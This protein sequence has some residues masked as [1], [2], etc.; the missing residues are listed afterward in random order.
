MVNPSRGPVQTRQ[1]F[2]ELRRR[3]LHGE[4]ASNARVNIAAVAAELQSSTGAVREA[5]AMLEAEAFVVSEPMKGYR[6]R[7]ISPEDLRN[8]V[9]ARIDIDN[10]CLADALAHGGDDWEASIVAAQ[11]RLKRIRERDG[12]ACHVSAEWAAAHMAFHR[13]VV[14]GCTN[15]WLLRMHDMLYAQSERYRFLSIRMS[16]SLRDVDT[17]HQQLVDALLARDLETSRAIMKA[18]LLRTA[19]PWLDDGMAAHSGPIGT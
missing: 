11:H 5:L 18:H 9:A 10:L 8:L 6:V 19:S 17:E 12:P 1:V 3:I 4:L 13:A 7:P 14:A 16:G 2:E 15:P